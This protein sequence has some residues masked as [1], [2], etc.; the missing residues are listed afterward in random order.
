MFECKFNLQVKL[1]PDQLNLRHRSRRDCTTSLAEFVEPS[2]VEKLKS[3][4]AV[5]VVVVVVMKAPNNK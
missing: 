1:S 3:F 5:V 2:Y 4:I